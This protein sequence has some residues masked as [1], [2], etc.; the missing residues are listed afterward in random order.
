MY[1]QAHDVLIHGKVDSLWLGPYIIS[2]D[3]GKGVYLLEDFEGHLLPNPCKE[4]YLNKY[5]P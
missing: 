4:L 5:Y 2:K 1:D 3:L